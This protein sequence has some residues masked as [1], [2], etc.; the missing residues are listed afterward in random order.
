MKYTNYIKEESRNVESL[1]IQ[2][3]SN[4]KTRNFPL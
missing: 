3:L 4:R 2:N 1:Q